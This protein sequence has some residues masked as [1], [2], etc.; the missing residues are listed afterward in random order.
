[1]LLTFGARS[2]RS[3][4]TGAALGTLSMFG[5]ALVKLGAVVLDGAALVKLG[6]THGAAHGALGARSAR[7]C[8]TAQPSGRSRCSAQPS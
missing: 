6:A 1:M 8:S 5:A 2:A 7:S 3:C 4:S